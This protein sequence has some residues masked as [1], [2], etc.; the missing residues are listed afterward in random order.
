MD[1]MNNKKIC[2]YCNYIAVDGEWT[3]QKKIECER[4]ASNLYGVIPMDNP[5]R[6]KGFI[7][8]IRN[9]GRTINHVNEDLGYVKYVKKHPGRI[10]ICSSDIGNKI[11]PVNDMPLIIEVEINYCP[12]CGQKLGIMS[13]DI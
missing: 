5:E 1:K 4:I 12:F 10:E 9:F 8:F 11:F 13:T 7:A 2:P 6:H 3:A